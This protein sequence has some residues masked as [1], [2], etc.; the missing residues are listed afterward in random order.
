MDNGKYDVAD[1]GYI[2]KIN[3]D[4]EKIYPCDDCG[5]MRGKNEGGTVFTVCD[6]CWDKH[7]K[8]IKGE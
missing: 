1:L 5:K 7:F 2:N 6:A 8:T 3:A 4:D